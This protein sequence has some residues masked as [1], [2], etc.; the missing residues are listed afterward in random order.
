M[1]NAETCVI[2]E[3]DCVWER[4]HRGLRIDLKRPNQK[5]RQLIV[6]AQT[7]DDGDVDRIRLL[8]A[9]TDVTDMR[10]VYRR[11]DAGEH[12]RHQAVALHQESMAA[13]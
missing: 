11:S 7:L 10:A 1:G 12:G 3:S 13:C 2:A 5:T 9:I 6:N 8:V 4:K